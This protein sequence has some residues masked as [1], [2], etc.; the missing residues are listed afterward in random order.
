[1]KA[2]QI[3][4]RG[5]HLDDFST[6]DTVFIGISKAATAPFVYFYLLYC[7]S[8]PQVVWHPSELSLAN[9][10]LPLIPLFVVYDFFYT[11]LHWFLH[12]QAVYPYIHKHHHVQKAPSR[13]NVDAINVHPLEYFLGEYNHLMVLYLCNEFLF[14]KVHVVGAILFLAVGGWL[15]GLNHT[16]YDLQWTLFGSKIRLFDSKAHDVHHRMPQTNYGQYTMLWD[17]IF[18]SYL[19]V[20]PLRSS[21]ST[22]SDELSNPF[23]VRS[24]N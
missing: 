20:W 16:R 18:G 17:Y 3:P 7:H 8:A 2:K 5:K 13:A 12:L 11:L 14:L 1:M 23:A 15:A 4:V 6:K 24:F 22:S 21:T 10:V 19:Y 9:L